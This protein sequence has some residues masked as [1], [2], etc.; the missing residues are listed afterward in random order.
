[1]AA[2]S[3]RDFLKLSS[4]VLLAAC[5]L[6]GLGAL[7]RFLGYQTEPP[8]PTQFDLGPASNY[9]VGSRTVISD[10]PAVLLHT[11]AGFSALS[12]VCTHLGC[13]L[14][15]TT[16]GFTCPCH[17]SHFRADGTV[18]RGPAE[19][20]LAVL[21]VELTAEGHLILYRV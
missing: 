19:K 4:Q 16:E 14:K 12:L 11:E 21:R 1:M 18:L 3:R 6:L 17:G 10:V 5:G 7:L 8:P 2:L 9:P 13:T 20:S 15:Q